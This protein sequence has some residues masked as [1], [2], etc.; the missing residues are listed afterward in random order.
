MI[1]NAYL[2]KESKMKCCAG[3]KKKKKS[4]FGHHFND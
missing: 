1:R 2:P 3:G 4:I